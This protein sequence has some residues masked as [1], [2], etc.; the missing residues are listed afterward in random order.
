[1]QP[2]GNKWFVAA[3]CAA[4][5]GCSNVA[6]APGADQV[7]STTDA[8]D[9][10]ACASLGE[11]ATPP[12]MATDGDAQ[13]QL[14][15]ETAALGGD[16]LLFTSPMLRSG[17]AY[18]C[19]KAAA[20]GSS[21]QPR[22]PGATPLL[23]LAPVE[24]VQAQVDA[25]NRHDLDKVLSL[26]ADDVQIF[27]YPDRLL[28]SGKGALRERYRALLAPAQAHVAVVRRMAFDRFVMDRQE[29]TGTS[30]SEVPGPAAL[31]EV[32]EGHIVRVTWLHPRD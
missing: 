21:R 14:Q 31:Y 23:V 7:R 3:M 25:F 18:R 27:D 17:A 13:R 10:A 16:V 20:A 26:Y 24:V 19:S 4:A 12:A 1:M 22:A 9:V 15:N 5:A 28:L 6:L 30:S 32:R 11:L 2:M 29:F 8:G